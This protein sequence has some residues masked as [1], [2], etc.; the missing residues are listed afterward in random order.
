MMFIKVM[1]DN[2]WAVFSHCCVF[3]CIFCL[4]CIP[5]VMQKQILGEMGSWMFVW[6]QVVS[7]IFTPEII[8]IW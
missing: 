8:R 3:Q 6:W 4:V 5:L 7:E 1:I 2:V